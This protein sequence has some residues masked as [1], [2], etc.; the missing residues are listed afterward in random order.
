[1]KP[2]WALQEAVVAR[3]DEVKPLWALQQGVAEDS[4]FVKLPRLTDNAAGSLLAAAYPEY[5]LT[6]DSRVAPNAAA[7]C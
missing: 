1:M 7:S 6:S 2:L 5:A 3:V 4:R